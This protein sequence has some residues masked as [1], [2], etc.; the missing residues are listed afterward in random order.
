MTIQDALH[1][2]RPNAEWV[3]V[4]NTYAGL[5]WLDGT[6]SKPTEVE[7]NIHISNNLYKENRR[8]AYP[9]VGDQLDDLR[10]AGPS[11]TDMFNIIHAIKGKYPTP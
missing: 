11:R 7:I 5:N 3:M 2:I 8:K 1:S 9:A 4:G 10:Q 6:Q